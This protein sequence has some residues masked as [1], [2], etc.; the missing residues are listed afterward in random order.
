MGFFGTN[1]FESAIEKKRRIQMQLRQTS[2]TAEKKISEIEEHLEQHK[3]D[4]DAHWEEAKTLLQSGQKEAAAA[5]LQHYKMAVLN[6]QKT[7]STLMVVKSRFLAL[8]NASAINEMTQALTNMASALDFDPA[9]LMA[10]LD[11][12]DS[13][14]EEIADVESFIASTASNDAKALDKQLAK[15][16]AVGEDYLFEKLEQ[17]ALGGIINSGNAAAA[18]GNTVGSVSE[19]RAALNELLDQK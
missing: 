6:I 5:S 11:N 14:I 13:S 10:Q 4:R 8:Q 18:Q 15:N 19:S 7:H 16:S 17:E 9:Q 3:K 1:L 12:L 2:R